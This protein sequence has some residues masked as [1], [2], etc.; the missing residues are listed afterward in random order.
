MTESAPK[1]RFR[2]R[3]S[4]ADY[5]ALN[6]ARNRLGGFSYYLW[7]VRHAVWYGVILFAFWLFG[8]FQQ[9]WRSYLSLQNG[10]WIP[11]ALALPWAIDLLYN[12]VLASLYKADDA[13]RTDTLVEIGRKGIDW[14]EGGTARQVG[15]QALA[16]HAFREDRIILFVD[17]MRVIVLPRGGLVEG[18][19]DKL[20]AYVRK[21]VGGAAI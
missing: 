12:R 7:P 17:R 11:L 18:D 13:S 9:D 4:L 2:Y 21:K 19:W 8:G 1:F 5:V 3:L 16:Y 20:V 14:T 10:W 6:D 15:W